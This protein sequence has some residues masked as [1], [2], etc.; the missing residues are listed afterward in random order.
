MTFN[1]PSFTKQKK[2]ANKFGKETASRFFLVNN[3]D[4][5]NICKAK[6]SVLTEVARE[7]QEVWKSKKVLLPLQKC[8][9]KL[10]KTLKLKIFQLFINFT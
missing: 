9:A 3:I 4:H 10:T 6:R 7:R 1:E 2:F 5:H 8:F